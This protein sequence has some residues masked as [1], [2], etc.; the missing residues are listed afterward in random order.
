MHNPM[1]EHKKITRKAI[2]L[3]NDNSLDASE[4]FKSESDLGL[5]KCFLTSAS[6]GSFNDDEI[7]T[8]KTNDITRDAIFELI[9][10][11]DYTFIYFSGHSNFVDR[12]IQI[13][14][15]DGQSIYESEFI[16][17]NKKQWIFMDCCR[18]NNPAPNSPKFEVLRKEYSFPGKSEQNRVQWENTLNCM[19]SFYMMYYVTELENFAYTNFH[20]G[21][22]TQKFFISLM[23]KLNENSA[24]S[25]EQFVQEINKDELAVQK[26]DYILG[27]LNLQEFSKLFKLN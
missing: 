11:S 27:N 8:C 6:G 10:A 5:I 14:L 2:L 21:Y 4:E 25:F 12:R 3:C 16:R 17:P 20:G 13:P 18:S 1:N 24:F 7:S 9:D 26:S 15:K 22:G 23:E 19:N